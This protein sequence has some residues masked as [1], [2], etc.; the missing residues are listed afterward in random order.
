[1][2]NRPDARGPLSPGLPQRPPSH[3]LENVPPMY[4]HHVGSALAINPSVWDRQNSYARDLIEAPSFLRGSV[5]NVGFP[6]STQLHSVGLNNIF[7]Q[8]GGNR[9]DLAMSPAQIGTSSP[10]QRGLFHG[11]SHM[12]PVPSFDFPVFCGVKTPRLFHFNHLIGL[13]LLTA[14][15]K[16]HKGTYSF[17]Y[18]PIDFKNSSLMN[19][20][21][22]CRPILFHS[23]GPNAGDQEPF[24]MG[25]NIRARSGRSCTSSGEGNHQ[26]IPSPSLRAKFYPRWET[27]RRVLPVS[28]VPTGMRINRRLRKMLLEEVVVVGGVGLRLP[29]H[30]HVMGMWLADG[31]GAM[32]WRGWHG[33]GAGWCRGGG[34]R[35]ELWHGRD[36][37][38]EWCAEG[39]EVDDYRYG[40]TGGTDGW[41]R[42]RCLSNHMPSMWVADRWT[43]GHRVI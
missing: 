14:I 39:S 25:P 22:H 7:S 13:M 3:I 19:E 4:H 32:H 27:W 10:Q 17:I 9:M 21:K 30:V 42:R 5:G 12:V 23:N 8:T 40:Q 33:G 35:R 28:P 26:D 20:D 41:S 38:W 11:R 29:H 24:P 31:H 15:D 6:V 18:L 34:W 16:N 37:Q 43:D 1:M 2:A 36:L